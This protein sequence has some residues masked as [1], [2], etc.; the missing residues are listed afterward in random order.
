MTTLFASSTSIDFGQMSSL[1]QRKHLFK[2]EELAGSF[3]SR[4]TLHIFRRTSGEAAQ[5][6]EAFQAY[7]EAAQ[8]V[9]KR[10]EKILE[11]RTEMPVDGSISIQDYQA[12]KDKIWDAK[13]L[14]SDQVKFLE[15]LVNRTDVLTVPIFRRLLEELKP[16]VRL[17][18][19][20][21]EVFIGLFFI[22]EVI[23]SYKLPQDLTENIRE[24][25]ETIISY[26]KRHVTRTL[27]KEGLKL[28]DHGKKEQKWIVTAKKCRMAITS[29]ITNKYYPSVILL[30][31]CLLIIFLFEYV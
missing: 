2:L 26:T 14:A 12:F 20:E 1:E 16:F 21:N 23:S 8:Y 13:F 11:Q 22:N 10:Y 17:G 7:R 31:T 30:I 28:L 29:K 27:A 18:R 24:F 15:L 19:V 9:Q 25:L 4:A 5:Q 3:F 6:K